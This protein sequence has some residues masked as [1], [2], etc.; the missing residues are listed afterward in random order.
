MVGRRDSSTAFTP[1]ARRLGVLSAVATVVLSLCYALALIGGLVTLPSASEPIGG[2]WFAA[3]ETLIL[4][5]MPV[6]VALMIAVD[7]FAADEAKVYG[8]LALV[9]TT[10]STG[11]TCTLHFVL[12]TVGRQ[13]L[14]ENDPQMDRLMAFRWPSPTYAIDI[15]AWDGF[16]ALAL[17]CAAPVFRG[18]GLRRSIRVLLVLA[19]ALSLAGLVAPALDDMRLRIIGI[20]GYACVFPVAAACMAVLFHRADCRSERSAADEDPTISSPVEE[21]PSSSA[22]DGTE[23]VRQRTDSA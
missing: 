8:R 9:F 1:A 23:S 17:L 20:V 18:S 16:F 3:M 11:L 15:L 12:L 21:S 2:I 14:I 4:L 5:L 7:D 22:P 6:V 10:L 13:P 19:G